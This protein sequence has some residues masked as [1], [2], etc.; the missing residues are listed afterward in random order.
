MPPCCPVVELRR[1]RT[2]P[3]RRDEL[4]ALFDREF[5]E[6]QE[7]VGMRVIGQFRDLDDPDAFVWLRG[8]ADMEQRRRALEAF[9]F[10]PVW[11]AH[12]EAANA[13]MAD[14]DDVLLLKPGG[15]ASGF[16]LPAARPAVGATE[17]GPGVLSLT[18][19][20][21]ADENQAWLAQAFERDLAPILA[22][23]GAQPLAWFVGEH[24]QNTFPRLPVREGEYGLAWVS[25][26]PDAAAHA[27]S[28]AALGGSVEWRDAWARIAPRL[29]QPAQIQR[30]QPTARSLLRG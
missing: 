2:H 27:A 4:I 24:A 19:L 23:H 1:Y 17:A 20:R 12:R 9:Y 15:A 29:A 18:T 11:Q 16:D 25:A 30:L 7:A 13:T 26:F 28:A 8:F 14:S 5:V 3:G 10:G 22:A 21:L 6:T